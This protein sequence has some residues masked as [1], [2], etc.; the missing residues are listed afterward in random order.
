[1]KRWDT[2]CGGQAGP[3]V[4]QVRSGCPEPAGKGENTQPHAT[5]HS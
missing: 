2:L 1:M 5:G 3:G 4:V